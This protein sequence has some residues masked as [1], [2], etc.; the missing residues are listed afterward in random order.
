M[1]AA[2]DLDNQLRFSAKEVDNVPTHRMLSAK[3][4]SIELFSTPA[5]PEADLRVRWIRT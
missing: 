1:L 2:I 3:A 4:N 5:R